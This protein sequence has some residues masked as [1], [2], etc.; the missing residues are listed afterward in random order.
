MALSKGTLDLLIEAGWIAPKGRRETPGRPLTW[1]T[2]DAFLQHFGLDS[3]SDLPRLE[4]LRAA[5]LLDAQPAVSLGEGDVE[6][7]AYPGPAE[8]ETP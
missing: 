5:G 7:G 4:E 1:G 8:T 6:D 3:V 2:T